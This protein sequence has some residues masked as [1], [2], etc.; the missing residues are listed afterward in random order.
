MRSSRTTS[1]PPP[2]ASIGGASSATIDDLAYLA[3]GTGVSAGVVLHGRL[4][5]GARGLAGE[6]G[7]VIVDPGGARCAC[8]QDGCLE[9]LVSGSAIARLA[10]EATTQDGVPSRRSM[11]VPRD[12]AGALDAG[13]G[14]REA[15]GTNATAIDVYRAAASGDPLATEIADAVGRRLAW[16]VHLLVMAYDV[17]RVVLGGGVSHAGETFVLPIQRELDRMRAASAL[18]REQLTPES[19][20]C[21][22]PEPM[23]GHGAR[24]HRGHR[25]C[26]SRSRSRMGGGGPRTGH[27]TVHRLRGA[28]WSTE[29]S[30]FEHEK[31]S[32]HRP[33]SALRAVVSACSTAASPSP[34]SA[35]AAT[36]AA[37]S[38][39]AA[40]VEPSASAAAASPTALAPDPAEAVITGVE[41]NAEIGFW[42]FYL[43]P[44][45]DQYIKDTIAR[46]E[47]TYP[48]VTVKWEDH[49]ATFQ[50]DLNNAFAA[51]I[52]PD[53]INLSVSEGWVSDYA[54]KGQLLGLNS[55]VPKP[56]QDIYFPGLWNEQLIDGENFQFPWYQ[57]LNVELINKKIYEEG[58]GL[59]VADFPKTIGELPAVC[60]TI[61]DKTGTLC[62]IRLTVNDLLSQMVYEGD[63]DVLNEAG[64]AF[65]FDSQAG[66]DW[67]QM[68]V[69]MV[70]AGTVDNTVL[71]TK[72]DR[73]GLLLFSAGQAAVL[74]DRPEPRPRGQVEQ[75][76]PLREP[77]HGA[78]PRRQVRR[79]GQGPDVALGQQGHQVPERVHRARAVLHE[80][81]EHGPVR[82]AG[83][84]LPVVA[85]RL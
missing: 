33:D 62:D 3:V 19:S 46:F 23:P 49:Q 4:H 18:A 71:T 65:T 77:R 48:G 1:A 26:R 38:S 41:A 11:G 10:R 79:A 57:G 24:G 66:V 8:G 42:T 85:C 39:A 56:V 69:D 78:D 55:V 29:R 76:D 37:S 25:P 6:I 2:S 51:G 31:A 45:F 68:Y 81:A 80:P 20:S 28:T 72:D 36:P 63:V 21:C 32:V 67:L 52:A 13:A 47:A 75:R 83:R 61:K 54:G 64:T 74:R 12:E 58:A 5:R 59:S 84:G 73:V 7:H 82:Q 22:R 53:V 50:A 17:E 9:T 70:A 40:S 15:I 34:S 30:T 44:T 60:Q 14:R 35:P 16:A 27:V 43:S